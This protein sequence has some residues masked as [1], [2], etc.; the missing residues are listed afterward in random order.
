ME[1]LERPTFESEESRRIYQHVERQGST[2]RSSMRNALDIPEDDLAAHVDE[3]TSKGYLTERDGRIAL[4]LDIGAPAE[5]E[6]EDI[7]YVVRPAREEDFEQL[8]DTIQTVTDKRTY[9]VGEELAQELR[10]ENTVT[11]HNNAWS[12]VF[13]VATVDD[14][15]VGW[16]HL[17]LPQVEKLQYTAQLTVGVREDYRGYGIGKRLLDRALAW[18]KENSY[19][20]VYN[21]VAE[22]NMNAVTF[23]ESQGWVREATRENHFTIGGKQVDEVMLA[24]TF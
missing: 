11:R 20:K 17:D 24:Y 7:T 12:R 5:Y 1:I 2:N 16:T 9:A 15:V 13:F 14:Y 19:K 18:A 3:L 23:L 4:E 10:Y 8:I 6:A 21:S 22:T